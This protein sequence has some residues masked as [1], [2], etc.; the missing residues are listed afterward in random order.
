MTCPVVREDALKFVSLLAFI[1]TT[2]SSHYDVLPAF[3]MPWK[4][5]IEFI[6]V[7]GTAIQAFYMN[8]PDK[9]PEKVVELRKRIRKRFKDNSDMG[10]YGGGRED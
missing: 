5:H 7:I 2:I 6:G 8:P 3:L 4:D 1:A 10:N 9:A